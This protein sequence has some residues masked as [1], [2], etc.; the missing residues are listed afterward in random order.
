MHLNTKVEEF[1]KEADCIH[2]KLSNGKEIVTNK[3]LISTGRVPVC[4]IKFEQIAI[5]YDR[6]RIL[7]DDKMETKTSNLFA[8][9]DITGKMMLAHTASKQGLIV[10]DIIEERVTGVKKTKK[11]ELVY[12][13]IPRCTFT[14]PE[15]AS[16]GLTEEGAIA[17]GYEIKIGRF[18]YMANGKA[19]GMNATD[20]MAKVIAD[21]KTNR[22]IGVHIVGAS[23]TELIAAGSI[24]VNLGL[25]IDEL[26]NV[27]YAHPTLSEVL[28]EAIEDLDGLAL[29]KI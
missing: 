5:E 28:M 14:E 24:M 27:I 25:T 2:L 19:I 16:V 22:V 4:S 17:A 11:H 23:A 7:I 29:H 10:A 6:N 3:V 9:G 13:N 20:G 26:E 12:H 1:H 21:A 15:L 18:T 8:I